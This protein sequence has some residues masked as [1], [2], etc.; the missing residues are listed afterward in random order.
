M[1]LLAQH[2]YESFLCA[3][4]TTTLCVISPVL[5]SVILKRRSEEIE[6]EI[7]TLLK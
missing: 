5:F 4:P 2:Q 6:P 1:T 3:F 7:A